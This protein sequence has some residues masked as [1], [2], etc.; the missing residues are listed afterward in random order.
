MEMELGVLQSRF[1]VLRHESYFWRMDVIFLM[2]ESSVSLHKPIVRMSQ[3]S[4]FYC[5]KGPESVDVGTEFQTKRAG[6]SKR[7][8]DKWTE[9]CT[10]LVRGTLGW[11]KGLGA[12][13]H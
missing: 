11:M 13:V 12:M 5:G 8:T 2:S 1:R 6:S 9:L 7:A 10:M 3:N 4:L